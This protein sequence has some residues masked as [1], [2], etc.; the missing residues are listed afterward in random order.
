V[1]SSSNNAGAT[2]TSIA[3]GSATSNAVQVST[4]TAGETSTSTAV[5]SSSNNAGGTSTSTA[6]A[7]SNTSTASNE[8]NMSSSTCGVEKIKQLPLSQNSTYSD[9]TS[10]FNRN[11]LELYRKYEFRSYEEFIVAKQYSLS[12]DGIVNE[13]KMRKYIQK[14]S[15]SRCVSR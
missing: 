10:H 13:T 1:D 6:G 9:N 15:I 2:S 7:T 3:S 8:G 5:D 11:D 12:P 4:S 14:L